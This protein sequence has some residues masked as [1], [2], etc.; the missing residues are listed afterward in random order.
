LLPLL[1]YIFSKPGPS[2]HVTVAR[3]LEHHQSPCHHNLN[4]FYNILSKNN[5]KTLTTKLRI[6]TFYRFF[7]GAYLCPIHFGRIIMRF[8]SFQ[9]R[10]KWS[11]LAFKLSRRRFSSSLHRVNV[12]ISTFK[13][14]LRANENQAWLFSRIYG[15]ISTS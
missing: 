15:G 4:A 14:I 7:G 10:A 6:D 8:S 11:F 1:R 12:G 2:T 5:I 9:Q 3:G 13:R